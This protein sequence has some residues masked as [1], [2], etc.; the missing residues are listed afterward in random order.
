MASAPGQ[1]AWMAAVAAEELA[2]LEAAHPG[3]LGPLKDELRRLVAEPGW[4]DDDAFA[5]ACLDG[6]A[7]AGCSSPSSSSPPSA[8]AD[9]MFTQ[10]SSTNKRKWCGGGGGA[11]GREQGKRRRKNAASGVKDRAD[12]AIDRAKKCL[13]KIRAIKRSLLACV[14]D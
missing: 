2:K 3:R 9:L 8:P 4:D 1:W 11:V 7:P 14:T 6:G 13:K 5:L 12:M 10:E